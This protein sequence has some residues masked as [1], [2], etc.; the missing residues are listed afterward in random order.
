MCVVFARSLGIVTTM[1]RARNEVVD[2]T[3]TPYYH[4]ISRCVRRAF[5]CGFDQLTQKNF[6][7][8]KVWIVNRLALLSHTFALEVCA[9]AVMSNHMHCLVRLNLQQAREWTDKEVIL[10]WGKLYSIPPLVQQYQKDECSEAEARQARDTV[11]IWRDR[12]SSLSWFMRCLNE[13]IARLANQEDECTGKFWEGRFKSQALLDEAAVL[14]CMSYID[15]NPIRAGAADQLETSNFTSIQQRL[16]DYACEQECSDE[17]SKSRSKVRLAPLVECVKDPHPN[18]IG[19]TTK[20]YFELVEWAGR[21]IRED[22][23]GEIAQKPPLVLERLAL[24]PGIFVSHMA[25]KH[26]NTLIESPIALGMLKKLK[27]FAQRLGT[28]FVRNQTAVSSLYVHKL[29][30]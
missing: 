9:Y 24:A 14:T 27:Q 15:L 4:C 6:D 25:G 30:H 18:P 21:A 19:F 1:T 28:M 22:K 12:L 11:E 3:V 5:L 17:I 10:R 16:H 13:Y 23:I 8:R 7:H 2:P 29:A 20:D 26:Q